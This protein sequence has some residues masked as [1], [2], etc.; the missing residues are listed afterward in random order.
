MEPVDKAFGCDYT[1]RSDP[2]PGSQKEWNPDSPEFSVDV[3]AVGVVE[4][5]HKVT[6]PN[7]HWSAN[8]L[9]YFIL[10]CQYVRIYDMYPQ[11][12]LIK[13]FI[14][15]GKVSLLVNKLLPEF[16]ENGRVIV[17]LPILKKNFFDIR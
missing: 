15:L 6:Q 13:C 12:Q 4:R 7:V 11:R 10:C 2:I 1:N 5:S 8:N 9:C 3:V 17:V 14:I 16:C